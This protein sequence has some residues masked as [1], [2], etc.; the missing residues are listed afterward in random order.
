MKS[1]AIQYQDGNDINK[2]KERKKEIGADQTYMTVSK[3]VPLSV[4]SL[5]TLQIIIMRP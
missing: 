4:C 2:D 1:V 3:S 5:V